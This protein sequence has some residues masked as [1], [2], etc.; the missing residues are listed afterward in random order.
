MDPGEWGSGQNFKTKPRM[1]HLWCS[2][3][4]RLDF[5]YLLAATNIYS[6]A[7]LH[8]WPSFATVQK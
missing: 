1:M 3:L 7:L 2:E 4:H 5:H 8:Q 6:S